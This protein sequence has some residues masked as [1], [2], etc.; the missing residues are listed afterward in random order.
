MPV[1][2]QTKMVGHAVRGMYMTSAMADLAVELSDDK[3]Q[4]RAKRCGAT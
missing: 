2:E 3:L 1:R 4:P